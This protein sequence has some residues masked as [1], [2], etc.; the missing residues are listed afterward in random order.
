MARGE[1][2]HRQKTRAVTNNLPSGNIFQID[3]QIECDLTVMEALDQMLLS[4]AGGNCFMRNLLLDERIVMMKEL[5]SDC[6]HV[7]VR[8]DGKRIYGRLTRDVTLAT[9]LS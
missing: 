6:T 4:K 9:N 1:T 3:P 5:Q 7:I 8:D 2:G